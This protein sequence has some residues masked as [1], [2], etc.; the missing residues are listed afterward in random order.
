[1]I[2]NN[3][4]TAKV[5]DFGIAKDP[6]M[7]GVTQTNASIGSPQ[8]MA[9]EQIRHNKYGISSDIYAF[10]M[11]MFK[12]A[13]GTLPFDETNFMMK[14]SSKPKHISECNR[15]LDKLLA[16]VIMK[17]IDNDP[18]VRFQNFNQIK[19]VLLKIKL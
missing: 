17:C 15:H 8:Y 13:T 6:N 9:P 10:G 14:L 16:S 7:A 12:M 4:K 1:M 19:T 18:K 11:T 3:L 2:V 5:V